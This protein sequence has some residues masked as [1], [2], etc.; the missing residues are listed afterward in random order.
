MTAGRAP[1]RRVRLAAA[2]FLLAIG[3]IAWR[4]WPRVERDGRLY[5]AGRDVAAGRLEQAEE[6][7]AI[8]TAERPLDPRPRL[9]LAEI[10]RRSGRITDAEEILQRAVELGLP[11]DRGRRVFALLTAGQD[12]P[13]A[14]RSL[15]SVV[16]AD[17]RDLEAR[18]A[19]A[20]GYAR[21][22]RWPEAEAAASAWLL[23][24]P[25]SAEAREILARSGRARVKP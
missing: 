9:L 15:L 22:G 24:E 12:F 20:E 10:A 5:L 13:R 18:R 21:A 2:G 4:A 19:L 1:R 14:E 17:P 8:L 23:A 6:R 11:L 3:P 16:A 7:L 25:G